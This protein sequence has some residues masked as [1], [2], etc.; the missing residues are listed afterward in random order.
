MV[1]NDRKYI[2][3]LKLEL[4]GSSD[5]EYIKEVKKS[6]IVSLQKDL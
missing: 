5:F 1:K 6:N 4:R 3:N 2:G